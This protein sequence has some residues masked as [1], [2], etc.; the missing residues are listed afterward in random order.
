[1][2]K[3]EY[4]R[5]VVQQASLERRW[6]RRSNVTTKD[7]AGIHVGGCAYGFVVLRL[8]S[9]NNTASS[10]AAVAKSK[11]I[12]PARQAGLSNA[13]RS[14]MPDSAVSRNLV[15]YVIEARAR[16]LISIFVKR[17]L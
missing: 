4:R 15:E 17:S 6:T 1:M 16:T 10:Y 2:D 12:C 3:K 9:V 11:L 7:I 13:T 8:P 14:S 5:H